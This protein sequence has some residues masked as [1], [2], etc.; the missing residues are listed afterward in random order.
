MEVCSRP[1]LAGAPELAGVFTLRAVT[2]RSFRRDCL[3]SH[4][5][6]SALFINTRTQE[7]LF[8]RQSDRDQLVSETASQLKGAI[9]SNLGGYMGVFAKHLGSGGTPPPHSVFRID[10][11]YTEDK[12]S[13]YL[14]HDDH[15][16]L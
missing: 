4:S 5:A 1:P 7:V 10:L 12:Y 16:K 3:I 6:H 15:R 14:Q 8:I 9:V 11:V 2:C 13:V